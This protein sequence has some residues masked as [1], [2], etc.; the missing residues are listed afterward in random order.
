MPVKLRAGIGEI[1]L[2][3]ATFDINKFY[4]CSLDVFMELYLNNA[5]MSVYQ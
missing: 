5:K 1:D 2:R 4:E 3:Q